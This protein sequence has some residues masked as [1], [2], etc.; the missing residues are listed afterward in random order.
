[1]ADNTIVRLFKI[2]D[3]KMLQFAR[4]YREI[5]LLDSTLFKALNPEFTDEFGNQWNT[6]IETAYNTETDEIVV[7]MQAEQTELVKQA[8]E[9][10]RKKYH[11]VMY[12]AEESFGDGSPILSEFGRDDFMKIRNDQA[13]MVIFMGNLFTTSSKYFATLKLKG[14][15]DAMR[16][17]IPTLQKGL[18]DTDTEQELQKK[19]RGTKAAIRIGRMNAVWQFVQKVNRASKI[20]FDGD[21][22]KLHQYLLP[23]SENKPV[24]IILTGTI[25]AQATGAPIEA[26][27]AEIVGLG[28]TAAGDEFGVYAFTQQIPDGSYTLKVTAAGFLDFTVSVTLTN[29]TTLLQN[30]AMLGA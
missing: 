16:D 20:V 29:G 3:P 15:T 5:F 17:E 14:F 7:D 18:S 24:D 1:M 6:A 21:F 10:C 8:M 23:G 13:A 22:T 27:T 12:F 2:A 28:L 4:T 9:D 19:Q 30:V 25:S 11:Q 26:A